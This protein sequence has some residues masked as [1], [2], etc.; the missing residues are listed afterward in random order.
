MV[1]Q[2]SSGISASWF[3]RKVDERMRQARE[4]PARDHV[5]TLIK[6]QL[7]DD[8]PPALR[9]TYDF[10]TKFGNY[11]IFEDEHLL[12]VNK[13]PKVISHKNDE[14]SVGV[15]EVARV[16]KNDDD[17]VY[18][19]RLDFNTSGVMVLGKTRPALE[20]LFI[21]FADKE[22][23]QMVKLYAT[24]L[25]GE[26]PQE[27]EQEVTVGL[28]DRNAKVVLSKHGK[29]STSRFT[30]LTLYETNEEIPQAVTLAKVQI[31]TGRRHQIRVTAAE[32]F[33]TPVVGDILYGGEETGPSVDR[34]MLHA[35]ALRMPHPISGEVLDL[36]AP[37]PDDFNRMVRSLRLIRNYG[38]R[39]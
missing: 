34:H 35:I 28:L 32:H 13:P 19:H 8:I 25:T 10:L 22:R 33:C 24:L 5:L 4:Y 17:I 6:G 14:Y 3:S 29:P 9:P 18:A 26:F 39:R 21:Q 20:Q 11:V 23:S 7:Y 2:S 16:L 30:P 31:L 27:S 37:I 38:N 15:A 36:N 12:V 1:E